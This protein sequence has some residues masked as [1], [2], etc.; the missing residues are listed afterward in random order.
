MIVDQSCKLFFNVFFSH[1]SQSLL[2]SRKFLRKV[3][4][5]EKY[6]S[7]ILLE[8]DQQ[9]AW[10]NAFDRNFNLLTAGNNHGRICRYAQF[11]D[12][13]KSA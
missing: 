8:Y 6:F 12:F 5:A 13:V 11:S 1:S 4:W 9:E 10:L 3:T 2:N 7:K